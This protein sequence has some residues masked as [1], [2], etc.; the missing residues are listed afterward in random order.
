MKTRTIVRAFLLVFL[1]VSVA[2]LLLQ[3][4]GTRESG[5]ETSSWSGD[6]VGALSTED[7][8]SYAPLEAQDSSPV[9]TPSERQGPQGIDRAQGDLAARQA[10]AAPSAA[11][12][13]Q[14]SDAAPGVSIEDT[15]RPTPSQP[16]LPRVIAYYFHGT[17][18]CPTCMKLEAYSRESIERAFQTELRN[19]VLEWRVVNVDE[20]ENKHFINDYKL[21][22]RSLVIVKLDNGTVTEWKN[23]E[24]IWDLVGD[25]ASFM[26][27]VEQETRVYLR[28]SG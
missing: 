27:Y 4:R 10:E 22:T 1:I 14:D 6:S 13:P 21:Y 3:E 12:T 24:R 17:Q 15:E 2:Y 8:S 23:L 26:E 20:E 18:R 9:S 28:G 7:E 5:V 19:D 11:R 25:K 16:Q